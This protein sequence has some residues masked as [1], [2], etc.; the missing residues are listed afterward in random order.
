MSAD[1]MLPQEREEEIL[2]LLADQG[3]I[4]VSELSTNLKVSEATI[5]RDLRRLATRHSIQRVHGGAIL[6]RTVDFEPPVLQRTSLHAEEKRRIGQ[7]AAALIND[8]DTV[9]LVGGSTT[10]EVASYLG[11]KKNLTVITDSLLIAE[12]VAKHSDITLIVLGGIVRDSE[13][14]MEG[15]LAQLCLKELHANKVV[16][17]ARAVNFQQGLMLDKVS[18]VETFRGSMRIADEVI[19]VVDHSKFE[20]VAT[21]VL[22]PLT[23]VD[24]IVTDNGT[25]PEIAGKL[26]DLG[27]EVVLA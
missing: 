11:Q 18:E 8:G 10:L 23:S 22:A 27:I 17:G 6:V 12:S 15:Y 20:Q 21:A 24:W 2:A 16:M 14:S 4:T 26:Q 5:R 25:P 19:L 7:A 9:I 3:K 13:L 1:Q